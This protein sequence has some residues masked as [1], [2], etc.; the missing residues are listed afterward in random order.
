[1]PTQKNFQK[2]NEKCELII[3]M[4]EDRRMLFSGAVMVGL[5]FVQHI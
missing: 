4:D 2:M 3:A 1:M 5:D